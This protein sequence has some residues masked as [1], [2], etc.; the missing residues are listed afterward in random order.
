MIGIVALI[1]LTLGSIRYLWVALIPIFVGVLGGLVVCLLVF[2]KLHVITVVF[3]ASLV[4]VCIDYC[5][6]FFFL[7]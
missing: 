4:G 7:S 1:L 2:S 3:G 6:H 5:L